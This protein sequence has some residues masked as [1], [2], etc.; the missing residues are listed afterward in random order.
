MFHDHKDMRLEINY[1]EKKAARN[2]NTQSLN[3]MLLNNQWI[4]EEC[5]EEIKKY[6]EKSEIRKTM[7]QNL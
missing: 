4:T 5:K 2:T 6:L 3:I 1:R 7:V